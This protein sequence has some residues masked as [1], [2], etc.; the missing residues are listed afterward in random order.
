MK[1]DT[2]S[3]ILF[4]GLDGSGKSTIISKLRDFKVILAK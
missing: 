4:I 2:E 1:K 3:K